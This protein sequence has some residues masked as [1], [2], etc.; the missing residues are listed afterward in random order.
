MGEPRSPSFPE[1]YP[2]IHRSHA[3]P[4]PQ[5]LLDVNASHLLDVCT[6]QGRHHSRELPA[7]GGDVWNTGLEDGTL[8]DGTGKH[9]VGCI[10]LRK[11]MANNVCCS[12]GCTEEG[13]VGRIAAEFT[14]MAVKPFK[15]SLLIPET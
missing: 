14:Y 12:R 7:C 2:I 13:N 1:K 5:Q 8:D 9:R 4:E 11:K 3:V 6:L 15:A 10:S